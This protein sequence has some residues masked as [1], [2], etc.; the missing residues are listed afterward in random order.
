MCRTIG[1]AY[2]CVSGFPFLRPGSSSQ[3]A[4]N[5]IQMGFSMLS[6]IR[7]VITVEGGH[8]NMRIGIHT[9]TVIAGVV[10]TQKLRYDMWGI[11]CY[12]ANSCESNGHPGAILISQ[13]TAELV[14]DTYPLE[15]LPRGPD[16][17]VPNANPD[18]PLASYFLVPVGVVVDLPP[19]LANAG[20]NEHH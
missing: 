1:D 7:D 6:A 14:S 13:V 15:S 16:L 19:Y 20:A 10:G 8:I 18:L 2:V 9:G 4:E 5:C 3:H 11:D 12:V 17:K